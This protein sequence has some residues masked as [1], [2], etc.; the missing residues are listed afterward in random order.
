VPWASE[1]KALLERGLHGQVL[2]SIQQT[3]TKGEIGSRDRVAAFVICRVIRDLESDWEEEIL[4]VDVA[5]EIER[6]M[7]GPLKAAVDAILSKA[8]LGVIHARLDDLLKA[9]ESGPNRVY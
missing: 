1:V 8:P 9:H 6:R 3:C 4:P 7:L 5:D 2:L